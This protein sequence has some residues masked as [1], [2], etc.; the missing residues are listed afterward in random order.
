MSDRQREKWD[1]TYSGDGSYFGTSPSFMAQHAMSVMKNE[2]CEKVLELGCGQGRDTAHMSWAGFD[3]SAVDYSEVCCRQVSEV[4]E[5]VEAV[6]C[7]IRNGLPFPDGYFDACFS[8]MFFTMNFSMEEL[9]SMVCEVYRVLRPGGLAFYSVRSKKDPHYQKGEHV[10]EEVWE[11]NGFQVRYLD[12]YDIRTLA[13]RF[14]LVSVLEFEEGAL[15]KHL[16]AVTMR[17]PPR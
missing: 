7:D 4:V 3:V 8:H 10:F 17:R 1:R 5:E 12:E 15:P 11:M 13:Q 6:C 9:K 16:Y 2:G 14:D